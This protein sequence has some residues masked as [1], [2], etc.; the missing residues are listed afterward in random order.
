M[1]VD[2]KRTL[3]DKELMFI[4]NKYNKKNKRNT[5]KLEKGE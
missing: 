5:G 3:F 2:V 1:S 4:Y